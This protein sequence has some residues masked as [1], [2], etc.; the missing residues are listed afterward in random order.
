MEDYSIADVPGAYSVGILVQCVNISLIG[1]T[2]VYF[3]DT[4]GVIPSGNYVSPAKRILELPDNVTDIPA[5]TF[6]G[7]AAQAVSLPEQCVS[8]GEYA[9][10][11][12]P[13][14]TEVRLSGTLPVSGIDEHAFDGCTGLTVIVA[15]TAEQITWAKENGYIPV[16][17]AE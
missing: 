7:T 12:S 8:I 16:N 6:Q 11:D 10:A 14:L 13:E 4:D 9:F 17:A 3:T 2:T 15:R 5:K 1:D